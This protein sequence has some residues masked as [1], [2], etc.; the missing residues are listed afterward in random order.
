[1]K[2]FLQKLGAAGVMLATP[3]ISFAQNGGFNPAGPITN[4]QQSMAILDQLQQILFPVPVNG[5]LSIQQ[6][7]VSVLN[8]VILIA[9]IIAILYLIWAGIKY[10]TAS[11]NE[12]EAKKARTAIY[13]AIIG[14]VVIILSYALIVWVGNLVK[15]EAVKV[16]QNASRG[17]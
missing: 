13:N 14:I 17:F 5:N 16:D 12:E 9:A 1:M 6:I 3:A 11:T 15:N 10:I 8:L 2:K 4:Q 7:F